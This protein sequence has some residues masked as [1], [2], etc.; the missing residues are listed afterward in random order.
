MYL[1][2]FFRSDLLITQ[3]AL[4]V[5]TTKCIHFFR[6][7]EIKPLQIIHS[8]RVI[9]TSSPA[10]FV[11]ITFCHRINTQLSC[12]PDNTFHDMPGCL[13]T[14]DVLCEAPV[15]FYITDREVFQVR[16]NGTPGPKIIK[17]KMPRRHHSAGTISLRSACPCKTAAAPSAPEPDVYRVHA[18]PA[19]GTSRVNSRSASSPGVTFTASL[20]LRGSMV[21]ISESLSTVRFN[22]FAVRGS[23]KSA[24][25]ARFI[26]YV[27]GM[28]SPV[29]ICH[30]TS[31][32]TPDN[33]RSDAETIGWRYGSNSPLLSA[34][35]SLSA[36]INSCFTLIALCL[37]NFSVW[38]Y[39]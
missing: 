19:P 39:H 31:N 11:S 32:S 20:K 12:Q 24:D 27:G 23:N 2:L 21:L 7:A 17:G 1:I 10:L 26:K 34:R 6:S 36:D 9:Q 16:Q 33:F 28:I 4:P 30:R 18:L 15:Y 25:S 38:S 13:F 35:K 5:L 8:Q 3:L 14:Q 29:G 37:M 22:I